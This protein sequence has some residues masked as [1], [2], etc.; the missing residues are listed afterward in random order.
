MIRERL[1]SIIRELIADGM[2]PQ[3]AFVEVLAA[4]QLLAHEKFPKVNF[5]RA[6]SIARL[7]FLDEVGG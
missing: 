7:Q 6:E 2:S 5:A 3:E 4:F 1:H